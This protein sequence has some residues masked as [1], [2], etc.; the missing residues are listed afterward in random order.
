MKSIKVLLPL[1]LTFSLITSCNNDDSKEEIIEE[2]KTETTAPNSL[3]SFT[4]DQNGDIYS[5]YFHYYD[6][7]LDKLAYV[8]ELNK[9]TYYSFTYNASDK[10]EE[11]IK[12]EMNPNATS[13]DFGDSNNFGN[14]ESSIVHSYHGNN[15]LQEIAGYIYAYNNNGLTSQIMGLNMFPTVNI[16]YDASNKIEKTET[17][18]NQYDPGFKQF[19]QF[20]NYNNPFY[21]L[22]DEFGFVIDKNLTGVSYNGSTTTSI[23]RIIK[24]L[25]CISPYNITEKKEYDESQWPSYTVDYTYNT[26]N[27]PVEGVFIAENL[28]TQVQTV[29][30]TINFDYY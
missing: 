30:Y 13:I 11:T 8:N 1:F 25:Y 5:F 14:A 3:K 20:D 15:T 9:I 24:D 23:G 17:F 4:V 7:K 22:F 29:R 2:E 21:Y 28:D 27:Y 26:D 6:N 19:L 18:E 16:F 12:Y 10:I